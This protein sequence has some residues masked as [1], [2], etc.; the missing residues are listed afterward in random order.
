MNHLYFVPVFYDKQFTSYTNLKVI[1]REK[2]YT[3][4]LNILAIS[5]LNV[6]N[7]NNIN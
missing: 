2:L 1:L 3:S 4:K 7:A 5:Q 6:K